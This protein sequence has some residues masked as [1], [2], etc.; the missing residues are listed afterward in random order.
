MIGSILTNVGMYHQILVNLAA[1]KFHE[2]PFSG[3]RVAVRTDRRKDLWLTSS[4]IQYVPASLPGVKWPK[5]ENDHSLSLVPKVRR[6][7]AV[8]PYLDNVIMGW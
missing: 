4:P 5:L 6:R 7:G 8:P 2:N 1:V 3:C